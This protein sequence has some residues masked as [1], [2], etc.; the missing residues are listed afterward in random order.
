MHV[1]TLQK[2]ESRGE[3]AN[4][5]FLADVLMVLLLYIHS[6]IHNSSEYLSSSQPD[7]YSIYQSCI[8]YSTNKYQY[9]QSKYQYKYQYVTFKYQY[10]Y[11]YCA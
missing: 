3:M 6:L 11:K 8:K 1:L 4:V 2:V 7:K 10:Q 5:E 9:Q